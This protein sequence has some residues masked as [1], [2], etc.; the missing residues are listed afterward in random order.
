MRRQTLDDLATQG[1]KLRVFFPH[2][3]GSRVLVT[4]GGSR[5]NTSPAPCQSDWEV[6]DPVTGQNEWVP[7][8]YI[9]SPTR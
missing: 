5:P 7:G 3:Q 4:T 6:K 9:A 2:D 8:W 1:A